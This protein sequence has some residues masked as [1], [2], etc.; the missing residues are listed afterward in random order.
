MKKNWQQDR[1]SFLRKQIEK[2]SAK[3]E[4]IPKKKKLRRKNP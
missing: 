2:E 4:K 3:F 1:L